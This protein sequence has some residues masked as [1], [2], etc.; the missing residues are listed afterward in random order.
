M[1]SL[2]EKI[3][4]HGPQL[5]LSEV[6]GDFGAGYDIKPIDANPPGSAFD[7]PVH[8][9]VCFLNQKDQRVAASPGP[10]AM[11]TM[12]SS[13]VFGL[14]DD[15]SNWSVAATMISGLP[16]ANNGIKHFQV[17]IAVPL[18]PDYLQEV[19]KAEY[20]FE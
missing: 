7:I 6:P 1:E 11:E 2:G 17:R 9:S 8:D 19:R 12:W 3:L 18:M 20:S 13:G 14:T 4:K 16:I 10:T 15:T 5:R